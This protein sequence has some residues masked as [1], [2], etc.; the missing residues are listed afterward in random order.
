MSIFSKVKIEPVG[1]NSIYHNVYIDGVRQSNVSRVD[2]S[3]SPVEI[4]QAVITLNSV[5]DLD[6]DM[7][8]TYKFDPSDIRECIRFLALQLQLDK[9]LHDAWQSSIYSA[10]KDLRAKDEGT[11]DYICDYDRA[12]YILDRLME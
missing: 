1:D 9:D 11:G 4:P 10:L 2:I 6:E 5:A 12:G 3:Y 8:V 7:A